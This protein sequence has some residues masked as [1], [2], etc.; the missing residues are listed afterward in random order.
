[1]N[2]T[3][4]VAFLTH[5]TALYGAN[6]SLLNLID[7]LKGYDVEPHV[8][9]PKE[10][11]ITQ[12]LRHRQVP[13]AILPIQWW[14][15]AQHFDSNLLKYLYQR[16]RWQYHAA[17]RLRINLHILPALTKQLAIWD[18]DLV[19][20]NSAVIPIGTWAAKRLQLP[21]IWHL[22]EF[23]DLDYNCHHD[24]GKQIFSYF[25]HGADA[26][27]SISK[28]I[29]AYFFAEPPPK[30]VHVIYNGIASINQ[31]D[32]LY[33]QAQ[34]ANPSNSAYTFAIVSLI[35]PNKG[36]ETAIKALAKL[37]KRHPAVRLLVVGNGNPEPLKA[38][39]QKLNIADKVEFWGHIKD[40]YQAYLAADA[41]LMCS[42]NEG[43]GRVTVEAMAACRPVIGFNQAGTS[44]IVDHEQTGLLYRG[45][46]E[47]LAAC[48]QSLLEN[49]TWARQMGENGWNIARRNYSV[50]SYASQVHRVLVLVTNNKTAKFRRS[51]FKNIS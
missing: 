36:Q 15:Y 2:L 6:R 39:A 10:G 48:M 29:Q 40:P 30:T 34:E 37:A 49:P 8:V 44:E 7:G 43:M 20:T 24:W 45:G 11:D 18:I 26:Q 33:Q 35:H 51:H 16:L 32:R 27:I 21:H 9:V 12:A 19:Y 28:A 5:Y 47:E 50:E 25:L 42:T 17:K 41:V 3:M 38:L 23:V 4:R 13:V 1:M 31:F 14:V 22:R 46:Y